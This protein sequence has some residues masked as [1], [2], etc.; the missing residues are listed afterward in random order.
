M[1]RTLLLAVA[2]LLPGGLPLASQGPALPAELSQDAKARVFAATFEVVVLKPTADPLTYEKELPWS[3]LPFNIR[4]D[5]YY[6]IG[7][8]FAVSP[9]ELITAFHVMD[10]HRSSRTFPQFFIRDQEQRVFEVDQILQADQA[11]D[12]IR[13]TVKDRTFAK[14]LPLSSSYSM[15]QVVYTA[16]NAYGEGLV[17]RR[18]D[19]IGTI[20]E[21]ENGRWNLLRSSADVNS[22]NSGGPMLDTAGRVIGLVVARK[23]NISF[24]LPVSEIQAMKPAMAVF[25]Q[26]TGYSFTLVPE[27]VEAVDN[28]YEVSVPKPYAEVI[29]EAVAKA[30]EIYDRRMG[31][32]FAKAPDQ[33][34]PKGDASLE[35]LLDIPNSTGVEFVFKDANTKKWA[36]SDLKYNAYE[37]GGEARVYMGSSN[38]MGLG[39]IRPAKPQDLAGLLEHPKALMDLFLKG[40]NYPRDLG[41]EK[42]RI[43][44]LGEPGHV[45]DLVDGLGRP[46]KLSAWLLPHLDQYVAIYYTPVPTGVAFVLKQMPTPSFEE[47]RYDMKRVLD[48]VYLPYYGNL[49]EW[50]AFLALPKGL[51]PGIRDV[52]VKHDAGQPLVVESPWLRFQVTKEDLEL[53]P[54]MKLGLYLGFT[55]RGDQIGWELRKV[56]VSESEENS[57]LSLLRHLKPEA[58]MTE[59]YQKAWKEV[60]KRKHPYTGA[61]FSEEGG[62]RIATV[63]DLGVGAKGI[64][65][66]DALY[67]LYYVKT[68]TVQEKL[69]K[70]ALK[71]LAESHRLPVA[72]TSVGGH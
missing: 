28:D 49:K 55:R 3:R 44:S 36:Y 23:D 29:R 9:K 35:A 42:I 20:P 11:R 48:L 34:F 2:I 68:G 54:E 13:F 39:V 1:L 57:Y 26:K 63:L 6:S 56:G 25:H 46:W 32:L 21:A 53:D 62:T 5:K 14:W 64:E 58:Q 59:S 52:R 16:G 69:M 45:E 18:G 24:S 70:A 7:T 27:R 37:A 66:A 60:V 33:Y 61:T 65:G 4:N 71:R 19:L 47:W 31:E 10:L 50:D 38:D 40:I 22:G 30:R 41:G 8:A 43:L 12:V 51:P 67:T 17:L 72:S 15:N